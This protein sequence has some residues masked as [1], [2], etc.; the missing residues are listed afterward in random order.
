MNQNSFNVF[1]PS[2]ERQ[3]GN[4]GAIK[5]NYLG[6]GETTSPRNDNN[7]K[8]CHHGPTEWK[9]Y[10]NLTAEGKK[11]PLKTEMRNSFMFLGICY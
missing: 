9:H 1:F 4:C 6:E 11:M 10:E 2:C 7:K 8:N 3:I 5:T